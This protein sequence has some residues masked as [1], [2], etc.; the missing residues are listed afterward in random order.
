MN[1]SVHLASDAAF[2]ARNAWVM[3]SG[4]WLFRNRYA[5]EQNAKL[6]KNSLES[7]DIMS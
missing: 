5:F 7:S 1:M 4:I 3:H 6:A 2:L